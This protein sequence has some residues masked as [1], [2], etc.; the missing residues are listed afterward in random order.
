M[1]ALSICSAGAFSDEVGTGSPK[2]TRQLKNPE[3]DPEKACPELDPG[4]VPVFA[5]DH[6]QA[7]I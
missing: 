6:A 4:W 3:H 2:N 5:K 7:I 1:A